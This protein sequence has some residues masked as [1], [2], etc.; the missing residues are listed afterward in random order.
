MAGQIRQAKMLLAEAWSVTS[1]ARNLGF[2]SNSSF[3][4]A[5]RRFT[6]LTPGQFRQELLHA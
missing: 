1:I 6:G 2:S 4:F 3:C 5:F